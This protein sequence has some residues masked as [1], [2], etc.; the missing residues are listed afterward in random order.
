MDFSAVVAP[1]SWRP[2]RTRGATNRSEV[3][4]APLPR[5]CHPIVWCPTPA[6]ALSTTTTT[7]CHHHNNTRAAGQL[8]SLLLLQETTEDPPPPPRPFGWGLPPP[9]LEP[10][11]VA[12]RRIAWGGPWRLCRFSPPSYSRRTTWRSS[13]WVGGGATLL[14]GGM[15]GGRWTVAA[16]ARSPWR[17]GC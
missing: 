14:G 6:I 11:L 9:W 13:E 16:F 17:R 12:P 15:L 1:W 5:I 10:I 3:I 7:G 8:W 4:L 2:W